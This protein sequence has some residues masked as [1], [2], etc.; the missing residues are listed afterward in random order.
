[1]FFGEPQLNL[2]Y[3]SIRLFNE[4]PLRQA[5]KCTHTHISFSGVEKK[6][7]WWIFSNIRRNPCYELNIYIYIL[8]PASFCFLTA[9][10]SYRHF[11]IL[12]IFTLQPSYTSNI[13]GILLFYCYSTLLFAVIFIFISSAYTL[14]TSNH[15]GI[16]WF[17]CNNFYIWREGQTT[18]IIFQCLIVT[19]YW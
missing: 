10:S 7:T 16:T 9:N 19:V 17:D 3:Y 14:S 8:P 4:Y 6:S 13:F 1:M 11:T 18:I 15:P 12:Y 5:I 2:F